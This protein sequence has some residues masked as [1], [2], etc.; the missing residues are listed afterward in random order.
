MQYILSCFLRVADP[1]NDFARGE[2][3]WVSAM[4]ENGMLKLG[5]QTDFQCHMIEH[6]IGAYTDCNHGQGLA[7]IHPALYRCLL[8][9]GK[10]KLARMAETVWNI[11]EATAE[12]TASRGIDAL[13]NFI[14]EIGLPTRWSEMGIT[15]EAVL[16]A[17]ADTCLITPGCCRQLTR[18]EI[19]KMLKESM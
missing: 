15:D 12:E 7:V 9:A 4:A 3:M 8:D 14:R 11:H 17:A 5:K 18:D 19:F 6:A 10:E 16:R 2:L 1:D 13:E